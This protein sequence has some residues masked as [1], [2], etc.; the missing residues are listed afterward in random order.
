MK[1]PFFKG[2]FLFQ[3]LAIFDI[4]LSVCPLES[5]LAL[6]YTITIKKIKMKKLVFATQVFVLMA[7]LP[8]VVILEMCH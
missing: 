7:L 8:L 5:R 6:H 4:F 1:R 2:L 3:G